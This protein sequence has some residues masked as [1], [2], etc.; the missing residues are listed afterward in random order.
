MRLLPGKT[1]FHLPNRFALALSRHIYCE[2]PHWRG[3]L[4]AAHEQ[5][6]IHPMAKRTS[7]AAFGSDYYL[8]AN[9]E[10]EKAG[11]PGKDTPPCCSASPNPTSLAER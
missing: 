5:N 10:K 1:A 4:F 11:A 6:K 2:G 7:F 9:E 3:N 8:E